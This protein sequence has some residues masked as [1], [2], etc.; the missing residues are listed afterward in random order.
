VIVNK[1]PSICNTF[2]PLKDPRD[3]FAYIVYTSTANFL[4]F[5]TLEW[6]AFFNKVNFK[7]LNRNQLTGPLLKETYE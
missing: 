6:K 2:K 1:Q 5:D 4:L 7:L 3:L